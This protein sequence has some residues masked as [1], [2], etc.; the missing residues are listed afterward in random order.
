M[1]ISITSGCDAGAAMTGRVTW[2]MFWFVL[3]LLALLMLSDLASGTV[4]A[5]YLLRPSDELSVQLKI[6]AILAGPLIGAFGPNRL[7]R[8][9]LVMAVG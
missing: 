3:A 7:F 1:Q 8:G 4:L 2:Q 5:M 6:A 9:R